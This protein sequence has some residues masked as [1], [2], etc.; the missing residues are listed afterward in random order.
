MPGS[1]AKM[2][3]VEEH[4]R[5]P[6]GDLEIVGKCFRVHF[7]VELEPVKDLPDEKYFALLL[8]S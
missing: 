1:R 6:V 5:P 2:S 8:P 3:L 4:K 7:V